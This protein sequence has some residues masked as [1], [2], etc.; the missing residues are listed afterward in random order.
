MKHLGLIE[1]VIVLITRRGGIGLMNLRQPSAGLRGA[2]SN[3]FFRGDKRE[4]NKP[5]SYW[6]GLFLLEEII[7]LF[8]WKAAKGFST[9][10]RALREAN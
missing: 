10:K 3:R 2:K 8:K 4:K 9:K 1:Y 5:S 6:R 7:A